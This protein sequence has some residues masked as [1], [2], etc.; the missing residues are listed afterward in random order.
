MTP[1]SRELVYQTLNFKKPY[2]APRDLWTLPIA[3]WSHPQEYAALLA[4]FPPDIVGV[5]GHERHI[6]PTKGDPYVPGDYTDE[7]G[8]TFHSIQAGVIGEVKDPLIK[9]WDA[10][11]AKVHVPREWLTIDRDAINRDC[12]ALDQFTLCGACPRPFEQ[13]QFLRGTVNLYMD[14]ID[15]PPAMQRF[16]AQHASFL[17]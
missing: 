15:P 6:A 13:M 5:S 11:V 10:D 8:C 2:R 17:L 1:T 12:D 3:Q 4:D 7:W 9:D 14:L 16:I